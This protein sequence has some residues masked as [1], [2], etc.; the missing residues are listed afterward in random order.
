MT[1]VL[2]GTVD[3]TSRRC[4]RFACAVRHSQSAA[5][6]ALLTGSKKTAGIIA[7]L[8]DFGGHTRQSSNPAFELVDFCVGGRPAINLSVSHGE[9]IGIA[10]LAGSGRAS[11]FRAILGDI[12]CSG[13]LRIDGDN[14]GRVTPRRVDRFTIAVMPQDRKLIGL[15]QGSIAASMDLMPLGTYLGYWG[16]ARRDLAYAVIEDTIDRVSKL[17]ND[18][19]CLV[20]HVSNDGIPKMSVRRAGS[21]V[22]L[23]NLLGADVDVDA[24]REASQRARELAKAG[25]AVLLISDDPDELL[26]LSDRVAVMTQGAMGPAVDVAS[27]NRATLLA[28]ISRTGSHFSQYPGPAQRGSMPAECGD[29]DQGIDARRENPPAET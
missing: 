26:S 21:T 1:A 19:A 18:P 17:S 5:W 25:A 10:G 6:T 28:A 4:L 12:A 16:F 20:D 9:I 7:G 22:L 24:K 13:T 3:P 8:V 23:L 27:F 29:R 15:A 11:L 14:V 2:S